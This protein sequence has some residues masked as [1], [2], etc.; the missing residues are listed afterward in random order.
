M[1]KLLPPDPAQMDAHQK[2][3]YDAI[4]SGPRGRVRGP[5]AVWLHRPGLAE[6]AQ[7][8]G[9]Y[10]RYDS[11][12]PPHLSELAILVMA[13]QWKSA[14]EWWAHYPIAIKAGV[15]EAA[16]EQ[17]RQ[18]ETPVFTEV[19]ESVVYRFMTELLE[20]RQVSDAL[21]D[22]AMATLGQDRVVDLVGMGGYYTLISMT[23]NVFDI[24]P[25]DGEAP[26]VFGKP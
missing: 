5:L 26:I 21:Y 10:C 16:L 22:E 14:F 23:L 20:T 2:R 7:A 1:P 12:L 3:V 25:P 11:S 19:D 13:A 15:P 4:V 18:G 9:Q 17:L 24:Q 6:H 8:L